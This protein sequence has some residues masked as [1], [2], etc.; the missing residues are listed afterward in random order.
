MK[1]KDVTTDQDE[2]H[3]GP[4]NTAPY[5]VSRMAPSFDIVD[6][7]KSIAHADDQITQHTNGKLRVIAEQIKQ[8][9]N[10]AKN[11]LE[12]A[13]KD[14]MLH[15]AKCNFTRRPGEIYHLYK[16][17]D[18]STYFSMLSPNEWGNSSPHSHEGSYRLELDMSWTPVENIT[19]I[20]SKD[21]LLEHLMKLE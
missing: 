9:Q 4:D 16:K 3:K 6:L 8:L 7:A 5:P 10:Q 17:A 13:Q 2:Y 18:G 14:Q 1:K 19:D 12:G 21:I 11:I 15:R 20:D